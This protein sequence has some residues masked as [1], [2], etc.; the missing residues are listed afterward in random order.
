M[1]AVLGGTQQALQAQEE[2]E[3][4]THLV[5][6]WPWQLAVSAFMDRVSL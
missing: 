5:A 1:K 6:D 4:A 3:Q 2:D